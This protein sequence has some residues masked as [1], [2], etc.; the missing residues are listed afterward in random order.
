MRDGRERPSRIRSGPH[1]IRPTQTEGLRCSIERLEP[2]GAI[3][4]GDLALRR[5]FLHRLASMAH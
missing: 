5:A 2:C 4:G 1:P 3:P